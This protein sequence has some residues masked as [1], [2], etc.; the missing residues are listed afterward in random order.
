[1][2]A[3]VAQLSTF[4]QALAASFQKFA[5]I[6]SA[7]AMNLAQQHMDALNI[8][9]E[10]G[11]KHFQ[12]LSQAKGPQDIFTAQPELVEDMNKKLLNNVR[13]SLEMMVDSKNQLTQLTEENVK[14]I[15]EFNPFLKAGNA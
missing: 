14:T 8:C 5:D 7:L 3:Q 11:I 13:V 15:S 4:N 9:V 6:N 2:Q 1:M 12:T 10:G